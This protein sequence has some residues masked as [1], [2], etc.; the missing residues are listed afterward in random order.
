MA[1]AHPQSGSLSTILASIYPP[2]LA[3]LNLNVGV[4]CCFSGNGGIRVR[5]N[6]TQP[7]RPHMMLP[8]ESNTGQPLMRGECSHLKFSRTVYITKSSV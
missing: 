2:Q 1:L 3:G 7:G 8:E 6:K 4:I 5:T